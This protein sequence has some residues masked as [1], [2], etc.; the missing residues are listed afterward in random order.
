VV[1]KSNLE[2][3]KN[4]HFNYSS[5]FTRLIEK[6]KSGERVLKLSGLEGSSKFYI[7]SELSKRLERPILY[8]VSSR[9]IGESA[10]EDI[11]FYSGEKPPLLQRKQLSSKGVLFS[12]LSNEM[13]ERISWLHFAAGKRILLAEA[14]AILEKRIP[15]RVFQN[16]II[17]IQKGH[18]IS[19]DDFISNLIQMGYVRTDFV[20][21]IGEV[22]LRG[23]IVDLF[24]PGFENPVRLE[25]I[26]DEI[27]SIRYFSVDDQKS[28]GKIE[29]AM[30]L[31]ASEIILSAATINQ[32]L[33][34]IRKKS[35]EQEI[36]ASA[37][38]SLLEEIEKGA[39]FPEIE[40]LLPSFYPNLNT[41]FD[42]IPDDALIVFDDP[43]EISKSI[44]SFTNSLS[45][46]KDSLK[47]HIKIIPHISELYLME[48]QLGDDISSFQRIL[49]EDIETLEGGVEG[50]RF[51]ADKISIEKDGFDSPFEALSEN[52]RR[53]QASGLSVHL[54][55][56]TQI[57]CKRIGQILSEH[58]A[59]GIQTHV[60]SLS[61]GFTSSEERIAVITERDIFGERKKGRPT[62]IRDIPSAFITS[63]SELKPGDYIVHVDFGIGIFKGLRRLKIERVEADF[64]ECE[65][66]GGDKVYVPVD[67]FKLVQRYLGGEKPPRIDRLGH[68]NWKRVVR[69]VKKAVE[70]IAKQLVELY[71]RRKTEKGFQFSK[72]D[73]L[74]REFELA[75]PYEETPDQE[76]AIEDVMSDM[77]SP[78]VMDRLICGDVGF[79]KTE[80]AIRAAFKAVMDGKQVA[81]LV[82]TTLLAYQHYITFMERLKGYP[83]IVD[84]LSRFRTQRDEK[85][86]LR[87]LEGGG[88]DIIIGTH[89][90]L[91]NR[92]KFKN[93]GLIIVDEEQRFGTLHKEKLRGLKR[94]VD[95]LTLSAT[96]IPRTL[97]LS[98]TGIRDISL[99]N[100]PPEGRQ[101]VETYVSQFN[102][103][104]VREAITREIKR[105]GAVFFIHNRI[106]SIFKVSE[107]I[108]KL[109]PEAR[110]DITHGRMEER[111]LEK[112][113]SKFIQG[114]TDVLVTTAIVESGLDIPRANTIII[115]DAH[116]FGLADLYQLRGRVGR[117]ER[118]AY[119]YFLIPTRD[120]RS[121]MKSSGIAP[122]VTPDAKR[123]L[124]AIA[125]L[126]ELGSGF[127]L[128][129]SDLEIR[130]AGNLFG[131]EQ[132][133]HIADVGLELYLDMLDKAVRELKNEEIQIEYEPE[134][135]S[136]LPA[137]LPDDYISEG[138]ERLLLY[139]KISSISS[140]KEFNEIKN[141][142]KD[143]FGDIP[144][145]ALNLF[146]VVGLKLLMK[147]IFAQKIE[148]KE[149]ETVIIFLQKSPLYHRFRPSGRLR[150]LHKHGEAV[151]EIKKRL[152][153]LRL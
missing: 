39:R 106:E 19:R 88:I 76:A 49:I 125:E 22:S 9:E 40:W 87:K 38:L 57:E 132:S 55:L 144:E 46:I 29:S 86:I 115:D 8:L 63:F 53:W 66:E 129:L 118:K 68:Q 152:R 105:G 145:P 51:G 85:E 103:D 33:S 6:I 24:S 12:S 4:I 96:P 151:D 69:R 14:P 32:S 140:E 64:L 126:N 80:V 13:A 7:I 47:K 54:V 10:A 26:G 122:T 28:M 119:A 45:E 67:K 61:S 127:K 120:E 117:S 62:K 21:K 50:I 150:I 25:F 15:K 43:E 142:L 78:R 95:M 153:E 113:I 20:E 3:A 89:K 137:F 108:R 79:G 99:I 31:P 5:T 1:I 94:T 107:E 135:R 70:G 84:M 141:E 52:I 139:K 56:Q 34:Y 27:G 36:P 23:A 81:V 41:V 98:L 130:G 146:E 112:S 60:G 110:V 148:I 82:P 72:R 92:V 73:N 100:T 124:K 149:E 58:G 65:Y 11:A 17:E 42:Y 48:N 104:L 90:L 30:V 138:T 91:G 109:V 123:R 134:I 71:A 37:K 35:E 133:G 131:T 83:V 128:A 75:F 101:S 114:E 97:Q 121:P 74:F 111:K 116:T 16:S 136:N 44:E 2:P 143:R 18:E 147:D 77:E 102:R 59:E 93:L